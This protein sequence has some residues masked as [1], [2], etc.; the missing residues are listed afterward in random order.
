[1]QDSKDLGGAQLA[2]DDHDRLALPNGYSLNE[3]RIKR[4]LGQGGF[5]ITYLAHDERLDRDVAIKEFLPGDLAV[6]Q[7]DSTVVPRSSIARPDYRGGL[8]RFLKEA[9]TLAKFGN[10]NI[11]RIFTSFEANGTAYIVMSYEAGDSLGAWLKTQDF[12]LP[13]A[14]LLAIAEPLLAGLATVHDAGFWHRDIKPSNIFL[15][16]DGTPV[17]LDFGTAR[18]AIGTNSRGSERILTP[19]YAPYEQYI[20]RGDQGPWTDIYAMGAVLYYCISGREPPEATERVHAEAEKQPDPMVP[21]TTVGKGHYPDSFLRAIDRCLALWPKDRLRSVNDLRQ[22]LIVSRSADA[23]SM[24]SPVISAPG[25]RWPVV[26]LG[27]GALF[28]ALAIAVFALRPPDRQAPAII[29]PAVTPS[30][31]NA[32]VQPAITPGQSDPAGPLLAE[33]STAREAIRVST[34]YGRQHYN[35]AK[36]EAALPSAERLARLGTRYQTQLDAIHQSLDDLD[37]QTGDLFRQY[38][39]LVDQL[40]QHPDEFERIRPELTALNLSEPEKL[41]RQHLIEQVEASEHGPIDTAL[42]QTSLDRS[43]GAAELW[44]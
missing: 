27:G 36:K 41:A 15:R 3:Y 14:R 2:S 30:P 33:A 32:S 13:F 22:A 23:R 4:V 18:Q 7:F 25:Q 10:P 1:M 6:R 19:H 34:Q 9:R 44:R 38:T 26:G 28:L 31:G 17:L 39:S 21:A 20:V 8:E 24:T 5:G 12:P 11:V 35:H 29:P 42:L 40:A 37:R 16:A 43:Y